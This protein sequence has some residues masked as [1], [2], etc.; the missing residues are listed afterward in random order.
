MGPLREKPLNQSDSQ[1]HNLEIG[2]HDTYS[3][4]RDIVRAWLD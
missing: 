3:P 2:G 4:R 1:F